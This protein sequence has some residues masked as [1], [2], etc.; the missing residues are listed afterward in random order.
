MDLIADITNPE[1]NFRGT[2]YEFFMSRE[3]LADNAGVALS[4]VS[5]ALKHLV[6]DGWL[7]IMCKSHRSP[8]SYRMIIDRR[9]PA[10]KLLRAPAEESKR[11]KIWVDAYIVYRA[12]NPAPP[13][14]NQPNAVVAP[15]RPRL[16]AVPQ[17]RE[18]N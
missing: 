2:K 5:R 12:E 1:L 3:T 18:A 9:R 17:L 11:E 16:R 7:E 13:D 14:L 15:S 4:T 10:R 8:S 6:D